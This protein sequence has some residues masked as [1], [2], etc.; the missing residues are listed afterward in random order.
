MIKRIKAYKNIERKIATDTFLETTSPKGLVT[1][2]V[3][4]AAL[5]KNVMIVVTKI[6]L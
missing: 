4:P 1:R 6:D 2:I 3:Q 5:K